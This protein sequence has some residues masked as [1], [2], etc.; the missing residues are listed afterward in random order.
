MVYKGS[1][2]SEQDIIYSARSLL[3]KRS[4]VF[5]LLAASGEPVCG[6]NRIQKYDL[7][8]P[9]LQNVFTNHL[10]KAVGKKCGVNSTMKIIEIGSELLLLQCY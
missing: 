6:I 9:R 8:L 7:L 10:A 5:S 3:G 2:H 1:W 4:Q